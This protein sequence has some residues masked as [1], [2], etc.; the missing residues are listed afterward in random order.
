MTL[1]LTEETSIKIF[2]IAH[3]ITITDKIIQSL[4]QTVSQL[5]KQ[6]YSGTEKINILL[7]L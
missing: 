7:C 6:N 5:S 1:P 2:L 3:K 4:K